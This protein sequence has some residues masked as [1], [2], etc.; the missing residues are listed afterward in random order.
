MVSCLVVVDMISKILT[1][2]CVYI[3]YGDRY[4]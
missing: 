4:S 2:V 1:R 3:E